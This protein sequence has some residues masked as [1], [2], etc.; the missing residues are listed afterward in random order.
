MKATFYS[1]LFGLP[2]ALLAAIY[3]SEFLPRRTRTRVKPVIEVMASLPSVVLGFLAA[4]VFAPMV[5]GHVVGVLSVLLVGPFFLLLGAHF[6]QLLPRDVAR[7]W[8]RG[9][10]SLP[11]WRS[12][13]APSSPG[14]SP[15]RW[16]RCSSKGTSRRGSKAASVRVCQAGSCC[17]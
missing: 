10:R 12:P 11:S 3:T 8:P 13:S 7:A 2:V 15:R 9:D 4:L 1:M 6:W 16:N 5:E 17:Y 14:G